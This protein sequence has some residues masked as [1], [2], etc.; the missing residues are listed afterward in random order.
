M[1]LLANQKLRI[2][3]RNRKRRSVVSCI[4]GSIL[5]F[6]LDRHMHKKYAHFWVLVCCKIQ[7][8]C[9]V[10]RVIF[11]LGLPVDWDFFRVVIIEKK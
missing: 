7:K 10:Y 1:C 8:V 5:N 3:T 2:A 4:F 9:A 6:W 11:I